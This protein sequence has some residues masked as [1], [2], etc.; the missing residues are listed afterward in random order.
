MRTKLSARAGVLPWVWNHPANQ[1]H[2]LAAV[3]RVLAFQARGRVLHRTT[4]GTLGET[5][6]PVQELLIKHGYVLHRVAP[7]GALVP[8]QDP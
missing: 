4:I 5:R 1:G 3:A 6:E 7:G 2:R 8:V